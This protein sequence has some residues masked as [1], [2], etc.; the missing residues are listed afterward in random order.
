MQEMMACPP[1][2]PSWIGGAA[3]LPV[4]AHY[5]DEYLCDGGDRGYPVRYDSDMRLGL[6]TEDT[7]AEYTDDTG[8]THVK[9]TNKVCVYAPRFG[10]VRSISSPTQ[11]TAVDKLASADKF[12]R[13]AGVRNRD[14]TILHN[15]NVVLGNYRTRERASDID[16]NSRPSAV[17]QSQ[18]LAMNVKLVNTFQDLQ[19][20][21]SGQLV[22][23]DE[24]RL[25]KG[26]Q[27]A[28][29]WTRTQFP[30]ITAQT[31]QT[32]EVIGQFLPGEIVGTEDKRKPGELRIVKLADKDVAQPGDTITF[33]IRFDNLG[34]RELSAIRI[35]DNLTPRLQYVEDS[36]TSTLPGRLVLQDNEEGSVILEFH[37]DNPLPGGKGGVVT[38]Q[39]K[40]R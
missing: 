25:A 34:E 16:A 9:P 18:L 21:H 10:A 7:V 14:A 40:V 32:Q 31:E 29:N 20:V 19:F 13:G 26:L 5:P 39:T 35:I 27:A 23:T 17:A 38:F 3:I 11:G 37:L 8:G 28:V 15:Q 4:K 6:E 1:V 22:Q 2:V 12:L 24:V 30:V 36:E 33:T